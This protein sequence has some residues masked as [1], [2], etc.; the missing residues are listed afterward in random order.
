MTLIIKRGHTV[1]QECLAEGKFG[2]FVES[3]VLCQTL[4]SQILVDKWYPYGRNPLI[5]LTFFA[6]LLLIG[7][8]AKH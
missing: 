3:F 7:Q 2:K 1:W 8:F 4:T 6:Q 5:R